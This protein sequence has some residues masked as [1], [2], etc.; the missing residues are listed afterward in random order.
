MQYIT[1]ETREEILKYSIYRMGV[2]HI[3]F[4]LLGQQRP[5]LMQTKYVY[6]LHLVKVHV[7]HY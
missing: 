1:E 2:M 5:V 7:C 6:T 4:A 3:I